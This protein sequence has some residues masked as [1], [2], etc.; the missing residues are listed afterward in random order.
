MT[1][2]L[3]LR[4]RVKMAFY[5]GFSSLHPA[6]ESAVAP[7]LSGADVVVLAGTGSGKTEA[8][9]APVVDRLLPDLVLAESPV[10]LYVAPT[11]AL[12]T[13]IRRRLEPPLTRLNI[14]I[15]VRHGEK[16]DLR[17]SDRPALLVTT[18]ESLE[19]LLAR[20]PDVLAGVQAAILDEVH[21]LYNTQR[22]LQL[23]IQLRRLELLLCRDVQVVAASATVSDADYIWSQLRP[24]R[25]V[26]VVEDR[27][28]REVV[29]QIHQGRSRTWLAQTIERVLAER[30]AKIL[31]FA[32]SRTECDLLVDAL[33][34]TRIAETSFAHH[35]S[36]SRAQRQ[37]VEAAFLRQRSAVCVATNTLQLGI[38]IGD[39]DLVVLWG[40]PSDWQSF[41]Q[42]IGRA[43]RR[44]KR[45]RVLCV[46]PSDRADD[47]VG[48]LAFQA[49]LHQVRSGQLPSARPLRMYGA[50]VQQILSVVT[51]EGDQAYRFT[52]VTRLVEL[53][54]PWPHLTAEV[55][56]SLVERLVDLGLLRRHPVRTAVGPT[57]DAYTLLDEGDL[58]GN[59][60]VA[61]SQ[62]PVTLGSNTLGRLPV[63][64]VA[65]M[66]QGHVF[67]FAGRRLEVVSRTRRSLAVR[68]AKGRATLQI[69]YGGSAPPVSPSLTAAMW[70]VMERGQ[71]YQD[72]APGWAP[73]EELRAVAACAQQGVLPASR[74][75]RGTYTFAG[76]HLNAVLATW[77]GSTLAVSE[78]NVAL[79]P[80]VL[81]HLPAD[82]SELSP[83]AAQVPPEPRSLTRFQQMLPETLLSEETS[84]GPI[85]DS[86]TNSVLIRLRDSAVRKID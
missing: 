7:V 75:G 18:P 83:W 80:E 6:Q 4:T 53:L 56:E 47:L 28:S 71:Y 34:R 39:I 11:R 13:D 26:E 73:S 27:R 79:R 22:G 41:L 1:T 52:S 48:Q 15:G 25:R 58:W 72:V 10:V 35:S 76:R 67:V 20:H 78:T 14:R 85:H 9:T 69:S 33:K 65:S 43:N 31:V 37:R 84:Q 66:Q 59:F 8:M 46:V 2:Q 51:H 42:R 70:T 81:A 38:D 57:E 45:V 44:E 32:N 21:E 68:V 12:V 23:G 19:V 3:S 62:V 61:S 74:S 17:S 86:E 82:S 55:T 30:P 36:L 40:P 63:D 49:V 29:A 64:V 16:D 60:P 24:G 77:G 54:R 5:G 50:A